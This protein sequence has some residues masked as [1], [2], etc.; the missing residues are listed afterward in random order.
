MDDCLCHIEVFVHSTEAATAHGARCRPIYL[1]HYNRGRG[2]V[3]IGHSQGARLLTALLGDEIDPDPG[4][5]AHLVSALL[6]GG[7][8]TVAKGRNLGGSFQHLPI[9]RSDQRSE[10]VVTYASFDAERPRLLVRARL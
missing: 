6:M 10:C 8:V 4:A 5:R 7:H 2:V 9:C 3:L 1:R